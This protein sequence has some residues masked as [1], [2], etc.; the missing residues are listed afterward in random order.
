MSKE[1]GKSYQEIHRPKKMDMMGK[2]EMTQKDKKAIRRKIKIHKKAK[3]LKDEEKELLKSGLS[4][5]EYQILKK[6]KSVVNKKNLQGMIS[7]VYIHL[8]ALKR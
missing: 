1:I 5:A 7:T 6:N 3:K 8:S 4:K 2:E